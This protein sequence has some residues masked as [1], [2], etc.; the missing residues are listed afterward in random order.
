VDAAQPPIDNDAEQQWIA[1]Y[2]DAI[3]ATTPIRQSRSAIAMRRVISVFKA[4]A[5]GLQRVLIRRM[6]VAAPK[7]TGQLRLELAPIKPFRMQNGMS[8]ARK[9]RNNIRSKKAG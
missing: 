7:V 3:E 4:A 2:R 5:S 9:W 1:K 6:H 8:E